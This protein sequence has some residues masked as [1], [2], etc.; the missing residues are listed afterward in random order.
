MQVRQIE[1]LNNFFGALT[2]DGSLEKKGRE[3]EK[4]MELYDTIREGIASIT[5]NA[6]AVKRGHFNSSITETRPGAKFKRGFTSFIYAH[7]PG[8]A[9][10]QALDGNK[11]GFLTRT[12]IW[13]Q[14]ECSN[15]E[16]Q[17]KAEFG[18]ELTD[19]L[20]PVSGHAFNSDFREIEDVGRMNL[21]NI[22]AVVLNMGNEGNAKRL[23]TGNGLD[24]EK[25]MRIAEELTANSCDRQ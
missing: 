7:I 19:L 12:L 10:V 8:V 4:T 9:F 22:M 13:R 6:D 18:A 1:E 3:L 24:R 16:Q 2:K 25:Q 14:D 5:A 11:Q 21:H 20:S 17:L 23:E 15:R